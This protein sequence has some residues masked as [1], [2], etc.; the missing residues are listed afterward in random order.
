MKRIS[1]VLVALV[2][3]L[4]MGSGVAFCGATRVAMLGDSIT[5][6]NGLPAGQKLPDRLKLAMGALWMVDQYGIP[7]DS[8]TGCNTRWNSDLHP[9]KTTGLLPQY[10]YIT[11]LCGIN[12]LNLGGANAATVWSRIKTISDNIRADGVS[13]PVLL[14]LLP[15][16]NSAGWTSGKQTTLETVNTSI[17][18]ECEANPGEVICVDSNAAMGDTDP[19]DLKAE[20][21]LG[22]GLHLNLAGQ[23]ALSAVIA[24]VLNTH[25]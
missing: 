2:S 24:A 5:N 3:G 16:G 11:I 18:D 20:W 13:K 22:D 1:L 17:L 12:D 8:A 10:S 15:F 14:T 23:D 19:V 9:P 7:G 25:P 6:S 4:A 21:D